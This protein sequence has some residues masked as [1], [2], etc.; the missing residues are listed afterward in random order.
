MH[1]LLV[2]IGTSGDAFEVRSLHVRSVPQA[3]KPHPLIAFIHYSHSPHF[4][5]Q[6]PET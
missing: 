6:H 3:T 2:A 5:T 4:E 1:I